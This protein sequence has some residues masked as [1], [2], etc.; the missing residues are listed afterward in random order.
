[1]VCNF[2][3][4]FG[5]SGATL[6]HR[7]P[8]VL[9]PPL[10]RLAGIDFGPICI[11]YQVHLIIASATAVALADVDDAFPLIGHQC[12]RADILGMRRP[13]KE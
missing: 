12:A 4:Q 6:V 1:M 13:R 2:R 10:N 3:S 7:H 5:M 11:E 8:I 9:T